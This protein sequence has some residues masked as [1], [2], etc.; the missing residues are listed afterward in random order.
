M[1]HE[2]LDKSNNSA[3]QK[4]QHNKQMSCMTHQKCSNLTLGEGK[5]SPSVNRYSDTKMNTRFNVLPTAVGTAP[6][7]PSTWFC[8]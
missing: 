2:D 1:Q 3:Q 4:Q 7:E 6:S 8:T 5:V